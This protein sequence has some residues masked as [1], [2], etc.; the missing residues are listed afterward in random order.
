MQQLNTQ[1][2]KLGRPKKLTPIFK[3]MRL[4]PRDF[5]ILKYLYDQK[6]CSLECLYHRFFDQR[7]PGEPIPNQM[8]VARQ[9]LQ[10]LKRAEVIKTQRVYSEA[11]SVYLIAPR[12]Y[13]GERGR[14]MLFC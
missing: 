1:E 9:R 11:K 4:T 5:E 6:F 10:A 7:Q 13:Q 14:W 3:R 8:R 2:S 12:G